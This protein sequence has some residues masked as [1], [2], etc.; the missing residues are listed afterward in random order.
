MFV[1]T[2]SNSPNSSAMHRLTPVSQRA[3]RLRL[4]FEVEKQFALTICTVIY[5]VGEPEIK[6][7]L[8]EH[9]WEA[10]EHAR[11]LYERGRELPGFGKSHAVRPEIVR[12]FNEAVLVQ[13]GMQ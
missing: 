13:D 8:S 3:A 12:V 9:A 2:T 4:L 11:F 10:I 5:R 1:M 6:Y 7:R